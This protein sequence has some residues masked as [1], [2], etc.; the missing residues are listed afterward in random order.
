M[1]DYLH[2]HPEF[3]DLLTTVG[4]D[5]Q[6]DPYLVA[7]DYWLMHV[8]YSLKK[9]GFVFHL[10]GGT[11]LSKGF[12]IIKRFSEDIDILIEPPAGMDVKTG[13]NHNKPAHCESRKKYY[14]WLAG[15]IRVDGIDTIERDTQFDDD[16]YRSGGIRL[17]YVSPFSDIE[18][19]KPGVLLEVGFDNIVPNEPKKIGSWA[20]IFALENGLD[21]LDNGANNIS[22]YDPRY[23]FVEKIQ[24][25]LKRYEQYKETGKLA[26]NFIRH[27]Y[28]VKCLLELDAVQNFIGTVDYNDHKEKRFS[29]ELKKIELSQA[30]AFL[31]G[32]QKIRDLFSGEYEAK[33]ILYYDDR[34]SFDE[35]LAVI[36]KSLPRL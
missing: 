8:L 23:T 12:G 10:K 32:D 2:N 15:E 4:E 28:D 3:K 14:D 1:P 13:K 25:I 31:L 18:A 17:N 26:A 11:S 21:V 6:I 35:I 20:L 22:C 36:H 19:V 5:M 27:Y 30:E 29:G 7:K 16:K 33:Q 9:Q 24:T 34:P